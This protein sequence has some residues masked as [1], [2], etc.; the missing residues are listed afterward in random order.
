MGG[1]AI[2][3]AGAE[4][5]VDIDILRSHGLRIR[6]GVKSGPDLILSLNKHSRAYMLLPDYDSSHQQFER[7]IM[8]VCGLMGEGRTCWRVYNIAGEMN[9]PA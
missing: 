5:V 4:T 3:G 9:Q 6:T 7:Y 8:S 2:V 1:A